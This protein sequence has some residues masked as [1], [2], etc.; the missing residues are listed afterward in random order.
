M[1]R[2]T[3]KRQPWYRPR[4]QLCYKSKD[5]VVIKFPVGNVYKIANYYLQNDMKMIYIILYHIIIL[6][7]WYKRYYII[8]LANDMLWYYIKKYMIFPRS[9]ININRIFSRVIH[10]TTSQSFSDVR[11]R[12]RVRGL[13]WSPKSADSD[14]ENTSDS[15]SA[16]LFVCL[17]VCL[18]IYTVKKST[19]HK[20][21]PKFQKKN[22]ILLFPL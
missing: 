3:R 9:A 15:D 14:F 8:F 12:V 4:D 20:K 17:F 5:H 10:G 16:C 13:L 19:F 22:S 21:I 11:V 1:P 6:T 7:I 18:R 2:S